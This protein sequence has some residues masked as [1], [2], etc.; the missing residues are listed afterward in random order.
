MHIT[1]TLEDKV[2][3][4]VLLIFLLSLLQNLVVWQ[5]HIDAQVIS[6]GENE[7]LELRHFAT[8]KVGWNLGWSFVLFN[9]LSCIL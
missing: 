5:R 8:D 9:P 4:E 3:S 7:Y 1:V 6:K 2:H